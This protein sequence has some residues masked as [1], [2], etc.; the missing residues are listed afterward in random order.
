M[1]EAQIMQWS[2]ELVDWET[3]QQAI[4]KTFAFKDFYQTMSFVNAVAWLS[5]QE[6]H[7]PDLKVSYNT[8]TVEYTTHAIHGLSKNDFI[9]AAKVDAL[10]IC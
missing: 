5:N 6:N 10:L 3:K 2:K 9:C 1:D 4:S 8:C 7:H